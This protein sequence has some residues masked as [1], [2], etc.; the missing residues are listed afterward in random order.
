MR[1][2]LAVILCSIFACTPAP[3][4]TDTPPGETG[5]TGETEATGTT[6]T[7][8]TA[9][10]TTTPETTG[11]ET[12]AGDTTEAG[13]TEAPPVLCPEHPAPDACC[14]FVTMDGYQQNV[15]PETELCDPVEILC[16]DD[17][18]LP[19]C[20]VGAVEVVSEASLDCAL[21][22]LANGA[23][24]TLRYR[25]D[26][27]QMSGFWYQAWDLYLQ[28]DG[29]AYVRTF[30][31]QDLSGSYDALGRQTID[32]PSEL[33]KCQGDPDVTTRIGCLRKAANLDVTEECLGP[34]DVLDI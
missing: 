15:C 13:T 17:T 26:S 34:S 8:V 33:T 19:E 18:T 6:T 22:A 32:P 5:T 16:T 1:V 21:E 24:G 3:N 31:Q 7:G 23:A 29:T 4:T 11:S 10:E 27:K 14:C 9:I 28:G 12:T 30:K 20:P 2:S 25:I